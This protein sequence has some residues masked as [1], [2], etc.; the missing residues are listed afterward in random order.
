MCDSEKVMLP[1]SDWCFVCGE[2]NEAG[3]QTRFYIE[4][5]FVKARL[6]PRAHHCG[7]KG[8]IHG[9]IV[10]SILDETMGWAANVAINRMCVTGELTVRYIENAPDNRELTCITKVEKSNKRIVYTIGELVDD[11]GTKYASAKAKFTPLTDEKTLEVDDML[12]YR[13]GEARIF[14]ELRAQ[15]EA[16]E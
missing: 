11:E 2:E 6:R 1:N 9:G 7:Y 13:G 12:N 3:L 14:D 15:N 5:G 4:D 16:A 10:A 8:V